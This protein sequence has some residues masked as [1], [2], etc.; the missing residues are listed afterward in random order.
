[1]VMGPEKPD[2]NARA[3]ADG[4]QFDDEMGVQRGNNTRVAGGRSAAFIFFG[5]ARSERYLVSVSLV[6]GLGLARTIDLQITFICGNDHFGWAE[7]LHLAVGGF[8]CYGMNESKRRVQLDGILRGARESDRSARRVSLD[9]AAVLHELR[10]AA[11]KKIQLAIKADFQTKSAAGIGREAVTAINVGANGRC[12]AGESRG[13][14][15]SDYSEGQL[16]LSGLCC[17]AAVSGCLAH[18]WQRQQTGA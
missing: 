2:K 8:A 17:L 6:N 9:G 15:L 12:C 5:S 16:C 1:M 14:N 13:S 7:N 18:Y 3:D 10:L 4:D 11:A